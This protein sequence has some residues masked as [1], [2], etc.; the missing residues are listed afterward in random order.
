MLSEDL[1]MIFGI[2][3]I[4]YFC[5]TFPSTF[6]LENVANFC[7]KNSLT[8]K[9]NRKHKI[10]V[11]KTINKASNL[12]FQRS[13]TSHDV[14]KERFYCCDASSQIKG[15]ISFFDFCIY[16]KMGVIRQK[17]LLRTSAE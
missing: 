14:I 5:I 9:L 11:T 3:F 16:R 8:Y 7:E 17:T 1:N 4:P 12:G 10:K 2:S 15:K 6:I 13:N